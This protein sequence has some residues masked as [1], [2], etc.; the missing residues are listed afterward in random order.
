MTNGGKPMNTLPHSE[1]GADRSD[2]GVEPTPGPWRVDPKRK[3]RVCAGDDTVATTGCDETH[4][5]EWEANARLI[6]AAPDL[7]AACETALEKIENGIG[8]SHMV[9]EQLRAALAKVNP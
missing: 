8:L 7:Y 3:L 4:K 1:D 2:T 6:A 5:D 9:C